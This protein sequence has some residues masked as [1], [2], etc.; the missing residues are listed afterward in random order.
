MFFLLAEK[1]HVDA[2]IHVLEAYGGTGTETN[3][4]CSGIWGGGVVGGARASLVFFFFLSFPS[5]PSQRR[6]TAGVWEGWWDAM[7]GLQWQGE[8]SVGAIRMDASCQ[9]AGCV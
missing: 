6:D 1:G 5:S 7:G 9:C 8:M 3:R 4:C 2:A